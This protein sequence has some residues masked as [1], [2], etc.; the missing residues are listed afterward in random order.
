MAL[1]HTPVFLSPKPS[2]TN[3]I[4]QPAIVFLAWMKDMTCGQKVPSAG[5]NRVFEE[6]V[7][8]VTPILID[9]GLTTVVLHVYSCQ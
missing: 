7:F 4:I 1:A 5:K 9:T 2:T 6:W 8:W 3:V